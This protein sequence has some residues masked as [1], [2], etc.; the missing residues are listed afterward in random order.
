MSAPAARADAHRFRPSPQLT[1][2]LLQLAGIATFLGA[3]QALGSTRPQFYSSPV[4]VVEDIVQLFAE[5]GLA[6]TALTSI[7]AL[8][9]GAALAFAGGVVVGVLIGRYRVARVMFEP[10]MAAFYSVPRVAFVPIMVVW[11]GID[12]RFVIASVVVAALILI[13]FSTATGVRE[14][15]VH[16]AEVSDSFGIRGRHYFFRVVL[17]G[18]VPF[19]AN[20]A[21]LA[22]QRAIT[23]VVVAEFLVGIPGLGFVIR[24]ARAS[25]NADRLFAMAVL[26][27]ILGFVLFNLANRLDRRFSRWRPE[28]FQ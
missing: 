5:D 19:I 12:E 11:F 10:Y 6:G 25:L 7:Y 13:A 17:P 1:I 27:M 9:V 18:A 23:A 14:V 20:G 16:Y 2:R 4:R 28:A 22:V 3:W 24:T 21:R 8:V 26:L 15:V